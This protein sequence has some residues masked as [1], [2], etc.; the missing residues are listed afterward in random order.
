MKTK[1]IVM[2][3]VAIFALTSAFAFAAD[4][5]FFV[6]KDKNGVCKVIKAKDTPPTSIAGPFKTKKEAKKSKPA[7][8]KKVKKDKAVPAPDPTKK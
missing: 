2:T 3:M 7:E 6:V 5:S 4:T 8:C 1:L